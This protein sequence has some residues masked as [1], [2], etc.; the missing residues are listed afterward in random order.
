MTRVRALDAAGDW[1]FGKGSQDYLTAN[2]EVVQDIS[3]RLYCFLGDCFFDQGAG[4]NWLLFLGS[5]NQVGL[6]LA[7][8]ATILN[9]PYVTGILQ[10]SILLDPTT[11]NL[12]IVYRVQTVFGVTGGTFQYDANAIS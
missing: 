6:N 12:T 9:T 2:A 5:K 10:L 1:L 7:V 4:I 3:T 11:R 8:N